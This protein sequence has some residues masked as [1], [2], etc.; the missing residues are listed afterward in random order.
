MTKINRVIGT[1]TLQ[2]D[3]FGKNEVLY[4]FIDKEGSIFYL[5]NEKQF[6]KKVV[7][8]LSFFSRIKY[9]NYP[10][11]KHH[12]DSMRKGDLV[13]FLCVKIKDINYVLKVEFFY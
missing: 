8:N 10:L 3:F 12:L 9:G 1:I 2:N 4:E 6:Y 11:N 5:L 13:D 7:L